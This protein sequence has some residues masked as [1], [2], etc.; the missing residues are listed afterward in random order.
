[1]LIPAP[2]T[3]AVIQAR[4]GSRRL[5][6]KVLIDI[7]GQP[8]L[9]RVVARARRAE[10]LDRVVVATTTDPDDDPVAR[11]C[12][13]RGYPCYR[14]STHDV[15]DRY[16]QAA[17]AFGAGVIVRLTGDCPLIDPDLI[18]R[19]VRA[20]QASGVDFAAN[21]LPPPWE[22]TYPIGLDVEVCSLAAL[23]RA[24]E[25]ATAPHQREHVMPYLYEEPGRFR[26]LTIEH[27]CDLGNLRWAV[28][29]REDLHLVREIYRHFD[30]SSDFSWQ[31]VLALIEANPALAAINAGVS[32]KDY[33]ESEVGGDPPPPHG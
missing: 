21:R 22:R 28:D 1:M 12:A 18:D 5:P 26:V 25:E 6:G 2:Q 24:W 30:G 15:L 31:A 4:S 32:H 9:A 27:D 13:E 7:A 8:M 3:I 10:T 14:G 23:T 11:L 29:T 20:F 17:H 16:Y 33:R 19:T